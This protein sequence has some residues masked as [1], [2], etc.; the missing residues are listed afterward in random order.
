MPQLD[1]IGATE[2]ITLDVAE[3]GNNNIHSRG[4]GL[5]KE[6]Q[7]AGAGRLC[8]ALFPTSFRHHTEV[9]EAHKKRSTL[10]Y[11]LKTEDTSPENPKVK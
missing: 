2:R 11:N 4:A 9:N 10:L 5:F 1:G 7:A 6:S 8:K 3:S